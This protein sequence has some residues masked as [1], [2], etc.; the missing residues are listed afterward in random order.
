MAL[1]EIPGIRKKE[2]ATKPANIRLIKLIS[3]ESMARVESIKL[4]IK[5]IMYSEVV[6]SLN[7]IISYEPINNRQQSL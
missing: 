5:P 1:P 7:L 6:F 3:I 4:A 2:K